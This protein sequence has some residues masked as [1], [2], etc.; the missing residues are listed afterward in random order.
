MAKRKSRY[1]KIA[2]KLINQTCAELRKEFP[3]RL[4]AAFIALHDSGYGD[5][6][7][8]KYTKEATVFLGDKIKDP[9]ESGQLIVR[10]TKATFDIAKEWP[11]DKEEAKEKNKAPKAK[12]LKRHQCT[13]PQEGSDEGPKEGSGEEEVPG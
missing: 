6:E 12:R 2:P 3:E 11:H 4:V 7:H 8:K 5:K 10:L 1:T 13:L 9:I